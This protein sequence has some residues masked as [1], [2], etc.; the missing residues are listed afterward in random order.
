MLDIEAIKKQ[1]ILDVKAMLRKQKTFKVA[2]LTGAMWP[3]PYESLYEYYCERYPN[4]EFK[5]WN[6]ARCQLGRLFKG[7]IP[8]INEALGIKLQARV[9]PSKGHS[10]TE[11]YT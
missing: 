10:C 8:D 3:Q 7:F 11:Y 4:D 2:E 6:T 1:A 9:V 5:I